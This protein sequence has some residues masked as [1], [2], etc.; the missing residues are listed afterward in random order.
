MSTPTSQ[1]IIAAIDFGTSNST[2]GIMQAGQPV[3][4]QP[5]EGKHAV[6]TALFFPLA[7]KTPLHGNAAI[8]AYLEDGSGCLAR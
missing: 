6:P 2:V 5:E 8:R 4:L 7:R 3:L 1:P